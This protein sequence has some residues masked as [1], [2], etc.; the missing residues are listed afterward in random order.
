MVEGELLGIFAL[1]WQAAV[2]LAI[3]GLLIYLGIA[4]TVEPVLLVPLRLAVLLD[5]MGAFSDG[6]GRPSRHSVRC[7]CRRSRAS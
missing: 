4:K 5:M 3:G 1:T 7:S 2:M 6:S